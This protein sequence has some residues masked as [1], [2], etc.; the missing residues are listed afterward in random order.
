MEQLKNMKHTLT[1]LVEGQLAHIDRADYQELGG[2]VDMIKDLAEAIYYCTITEAMEKTD[3]EKDSYHHQEKYYV[4]V[5][6]YPYTYNR[7]YRDMDIDM[8]RMYYG[9]RYYPGN[10]SSSSNQRAT[11]GTSGKYYSDLDIRDYRE[12]RSPSSRRMYME[13]KEMNHPKEKKMKELE[14]YMQ[15]LGHDLTEMI[16]EASP[17]EKQLLHKK[18]TELATKI[19]V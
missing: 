2:A 18:V 13:S 16:S 1:S 3:K 10:G 19:H 14:Q 9:D 4:P 15:E 8:G 7:Y 6:D 17:E 5:M 12:G 11:T